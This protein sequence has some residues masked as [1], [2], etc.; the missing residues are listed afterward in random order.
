MGSTACSNQIGPS[1]EKKWHETLLKQP[2][3]NPG[4]ENVTAVCLL[5]DIEASKS[6]CPWKGYP[7]VK[8]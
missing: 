5:E 1:T 8:K 6:L 4:V 3:V 7:F 2:Q